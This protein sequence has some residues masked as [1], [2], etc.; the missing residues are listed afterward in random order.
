MK[1]L[2]VLLERFLGEQYLHCD[3]RGRQ[4]FERLL[5]QPDPELMSWLLGQGRPAD[6]QLSEAVRLIR[7]ARFD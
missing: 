1:E 7:R 5:Q 6:A 4:A 2:D 3:Q